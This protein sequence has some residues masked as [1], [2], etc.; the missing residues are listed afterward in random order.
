MRAREARA[1]PTSVSG[2]KRPLLP[3]RCQPRADALPSARRRTPA[4]EMTRSI[5]SITSSARRSWA[6]SHARHLLRCAWKTWSTSVCGMSSA[7]F[8]CF[9]F[10]RLSPPPAAA[11]ASS[12]AASPGSAPW[13][14][15]VASTSHA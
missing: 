5:A 14:C 11:A 15:G 13:W 7:T 10:F 8:A 1:S 2:T 4:Y 12:V 6:S 9:R 3:T